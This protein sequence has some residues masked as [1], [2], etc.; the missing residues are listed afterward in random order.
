MNEF[1]ERITKLPPKKLAL[2]A[3]ELRT[4]LDQAEQ[5]GR[6]E[7]IAIVGLG[8]RVPGGAVQAIQ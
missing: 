8:C 5:Q 7:P 2:L 6:H 1:L 4:R 3:L